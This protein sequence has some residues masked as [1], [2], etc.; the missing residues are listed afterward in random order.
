M[1]APHASMTEPQTCASWVSAASA[2]RMPQRL[3]G[4]PMPAGPARP[5]H[6][7]VLRALCACRRVRHGC[8]LDSIGGVP[9]QHVSLAAH[10]GL[11]LG[12]DS[13][14]AAQ[15]AVSMGRAAT[16]R[17]ASRL[18]PTHSALPTNPHR[19]LKRPPHPRTHVT[20]SPPSQTPTTRRTATRLCFTWRRAGS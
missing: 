13:R 16:P 7:G 1:G 10:P 9:T 3:S 4:K 8:A 12:V 5:G 6:S 14:F 17:G 2:R 20:L 19:P 15:T 18:P 11:I